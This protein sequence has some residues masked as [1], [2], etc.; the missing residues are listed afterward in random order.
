MPR[1]LVIGE[2]PPLPGSGHS[3]TRNWTEG[4]EKR[5]R[6]WKA[7]R[8]HPACNDV[9]YITVSFFQNLCNDSVNLIQPRRF[10]TSPATRFQ[11]A[12]C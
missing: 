12:F 5:T 11:A 1:T 3:V 4:E 8:T 6:R 7:G 9:F 2:A 10:G